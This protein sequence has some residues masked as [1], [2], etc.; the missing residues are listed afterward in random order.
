M[1]EGCGKRGG[2]LKMVI[3]SSATIGNSMWPKS[4]LDGVKSSVL[5]RKAVTE[6]IQFE[7]QRLDAETVVDNQYELT[8]TRPIGLNLKET[9]DGYVE[10][11]GFTPKASK[12]VRYA[13]KVS[14]RIIAVD[15]SLGDRMWPVS[16]VEGV[17]S[18]VTARLPGQQITFRFERSSD[19]N[20]INNIS[21]NNNNGNDGT[22]TAV[23]ASTTAM[24]C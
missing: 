16:T 19:T 3:S 2:G 17:I 4:T 15:S 9:E 6:S 21:T 5:S 24:A 18:S 7:F 1:Q 14:D 11:I 22:T 13:V 23:V 10:I 20:I 12:L 8:L